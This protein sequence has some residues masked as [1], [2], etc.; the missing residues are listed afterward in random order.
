[1]Q[2]CKANIHRGS[3]KWGGLGTLGVSDSYSTSLGGL[4]SLYHVSMSVSPHISYLIKASQNGAG[5]ILSILVI[6][7][8][9][10]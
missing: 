5:T 1:M 4:Q 8:Y 2:E 3:G 10:V 9:L 7:A 6:A